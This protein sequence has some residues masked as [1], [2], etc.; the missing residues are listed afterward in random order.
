MNQAMCL[1]PQGRNILM[2]HFKT[3]APVSRLNFCDSLF[4]NIHD[5]T[6][7]SQVIFMKDEAW[8]HLSRYINSQNTHHWDSENH[9]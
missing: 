3:A 5:S 6:D 9:V 8:F 4:R 2:C 7:D 1:E